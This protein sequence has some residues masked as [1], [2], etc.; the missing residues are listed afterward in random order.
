MQSLYN[1]PHYNT[2]LGLVVQSVTCPT[3]D[4][5]VASLIPAR[6]HTFVEIDNEIIPRD[7]LLHPLIQEGLLSVASQSMLKSF[8]YLNLC[9]WFGRYCQV[10]KIFCCV[11]CRVPVIKAVDSK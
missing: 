5:V 1:T 4:L 10:L 9:M 8:V 2:G 6:T 3:A 7:I 11:H